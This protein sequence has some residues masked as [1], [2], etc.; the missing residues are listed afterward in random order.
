M[1]RQRRNELRNAYEFLKKHVPSVAKSDRASKQMILD[2]AIEFCQTVKYKEENL[3]KERQAIHEKKIALQ[4]RIMQL[5]R[6][7]SLH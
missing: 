4:K 6:Q 5:Q 7:N 2:K 1:E 3:N